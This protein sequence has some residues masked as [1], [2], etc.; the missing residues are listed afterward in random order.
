MLLTNDIV[1]IDEAQHGVN[2]RP[3]AWRQILEPKGFRL[4]R[5]KRVSFNY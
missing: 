5:T 3:E 1:L 4:S 2:N